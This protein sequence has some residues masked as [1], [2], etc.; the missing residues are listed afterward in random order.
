[1]PKEMKYQ[2][3]DQALRS[4]RF[5]LHGPKDSPMI[6]N[7]STSTRMRQSL[8]FQAFCSLEKINATIMEPCSKGA[9]PHECLV[10]FRENPQLVKN[11]RILWASLPK[12]TRIE[13]IIKL[14]KESETTAT[15]FRFLGVA[16]CLNAFKMLTGVSACVLQKAREYARRKHVTCLSKAEMGLWAEIQNAPRA[17]RYIASWICFKFS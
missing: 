6:F 5:V 2:K 14:I 4:A 9:M 1:M 17:H 10:M 13:S 11:F 16:V 7:Q 15:K 3:A 12:P 8:R